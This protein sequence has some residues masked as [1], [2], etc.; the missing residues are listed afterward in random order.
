[1]RCTHVCRK[2]KLRCLLN[3]GHKKRH[4]F[5][6]PNLLS[7]S[8]ITKLL[9]ELTS[10]E[11]KSLAGLDNIDVS[12]GHD[13]F[14]Q[15]RQIVDLQCSIIGTDEAKERGQMLRNRVDAAQ[16]FHKV[17]F[18]RHFKTGNCKCMCINC[19]L[20]CKETDPIK[21]PLRGLHDPPC[22]HCQDSFKVL[23]DI[24]KFHEE[25][26]TVANARYNEMPSL[27]D[28]MDTWREELAIC[29]TNLIDYRAHLVHKFSEGEF[30]S[31]YYE[32]IDDDEAV[33]SSDWKMKILSAKHKESQAEWFS[34][35]G[36]SL[37]GFEVHLKSTKDR[38]RKVFYHF[39][40]TDDTTQDSE[41]VLCAKHYLYSVVLPCYGV[42]RVRFRSDGA[43][44]FSSKE[45]KASMAMWDDIAKLT[46]GAYENSY[47][48]SVSGCGKTALDVSFYF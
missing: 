24:C 23:V 48:V 22:H 2:S 36:T 42:K 26:E 9:S 33:V 41:A 44:C 46:S 5:T 27:K 43:M 18:R 19:G 45:A 6:P 17:N 14:E 4:R 11:I 30:D 15:M 37:L 28:D 8:T 34:K 20:S 32:D 16:D 39:F 40:L 31:E 12:K 47:K 38:T 13:N 1:M 21:C 29:Q 3:I 25:A 35:R 7:P 10:G